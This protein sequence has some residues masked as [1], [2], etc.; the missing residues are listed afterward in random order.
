VDFLLQPHVPGVDSAPV[1]NR[2]VNM[3]FVRKEASQYYLHPVDRA[4]ALGRVPTG[5]K[6]DRDVADAPPFTQYALRH[7]AAN[8]FERIRKPRSDWKTVED[9]APQLA[10]FELRCACEDYDRAG[11]L[12]DVIDRNYLW[13][14]G[15]AELVIQM[16]ERL[17]G[18]L[19]APVLA[20]TNAGQLAWAY[21]TIGR[22]DDA[23]VQYD[24]AIE[25]A[26]KN[27]EHFLAER[28]RSRKSLVYWDLG[29]LEQA[30]ELLSR[31]RHSAERSWEKGALASC[32]GD[33]GMVHLSLGNLSEAMQLFQEAERLADEA[34]N[35]RI[36]ACNLDNLAHGSLRTQDYASARSFIERALAIPIEK[37]GHL[38]TC[39]HLVTRARVR[40]MLGE[41]RAAIEDCKAAIDLRQLSLRHQASLYMAIAQFFLGEPEAALN[42]AHQA[43]QWIESLFAHIKRHR[44]AGYFLALALLCAGQA[45]D[46]LQAYRH[47]LAMC[48]AK[49][50]VSEALLDLQ[51]LQKLQQAPEGTAPAVA[52]LQ[53][54]LAE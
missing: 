49:G 39:Y 24:V 12:L 46:A 4:Y 9:L 50:V 23:L 38:N 25:E 47:A 18:R 1:L 16:R 48:S 22:F 52:L 13:M 10:E 27:N 28:Y 35:E 34:G 44:D 33:N 36:R 37:V 32:I 30:L 15:H 17:A 42:N 45:E 43:V 11:Q 6:S 51:L 5:E 7:R 19:Q 41:Y 40:L 8:F 26:E 31:I 53:A 3:Q 29:D 20:T 14:W 21:W 54:T 2:L